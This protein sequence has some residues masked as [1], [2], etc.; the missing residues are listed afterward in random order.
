MIIFAGYINLPVK[1]EVNK[2]PIQRDD[3]KISALVLSCIIFVEFLFYIFLHF[4]TDS[5]SILFYPFEVFS[6]FKY[7][8]SFVWLFLEGTNFFYMHTWI[9]PAVSQGKMSLSSF[10]ILTFPSSSQLASAVSGEITIILVLFRSSL[11]E[12]S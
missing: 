9:S 12:S 8:Y 2:P 10:N 5:Y 1:G 3:K 4:M 7:N 6:F 11:F